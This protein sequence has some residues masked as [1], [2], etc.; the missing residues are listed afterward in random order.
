MFEP[1]FFTSFFD[2]SFNRSFRESLF[3]NFVVNSGRFH[4]KKGPHVGET[5]QVRSNA[6]HSDWSMCSIGHIQPH[7]LPNL[8]VIWIN[9][10]VFR[11]CSCWPNKKVFLLD[12]NAD[13]TLP[14][15]NGTHTL[16]AS[17]L[18]TQSV[19]CALTC[20]MTHSIPNISNCTR[21]ASLRFVSMHTHQGQLL[22]HGECALRLAM[23]PPSSGV[24]RLPLRPRFVAASLISP[25]PHCAVYG[26][27]THAF[28][29]YHTV[30]MVQS[31]FRFCLWECS[32]KTSWHT[33]IQ[34]TSDYV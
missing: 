28:L 11:N 12:S 10:C 29:I 25:K 7:V 6:I 19:S 16:T 32:K 22:S 14:R 21:T 33:R 8:A 5:D 17:V 15:Q 18:W 34:S 30:C 4:P 23:L 2:S 1:V 3:L 13:T 26:V 24:G 31:T 20:D 9:W 27:H